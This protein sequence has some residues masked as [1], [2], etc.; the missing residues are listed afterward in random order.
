MTQRDFDSSR[1]EQVKQELEGAPDGALPKPMGGVLT[2]HDIQVETT[3]STPVSTPMARTTIVSGAVSLTLN[4][5]RFGPLFC[6][7]L[8]EI[9]AASLLQTP[10]VSGGRDPPRRLALLP[11]HFELSRRGGNAGAARRRS[12]L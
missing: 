8:E 4:F 11:V 7:K 6:P 9:H 10:P 3:W 2:P 5:L 12:Q 1:L